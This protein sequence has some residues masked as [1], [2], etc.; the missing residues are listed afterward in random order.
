MTATAGLAAGLL[1]SAWLVALPARDRSL[2][3][4]RQ[5]DAVAAGGRWIRRVNVMGAVIGLIVLIPWSLSDLGLTSWL[6]VAGGFAIAAVGQR[7]LGRWQ[8]RR[9]RVERQHAVIEVCDA[10]AA[11]MRA[12]L[13]A[14]R[15]I[16]RAFDTWPEW[17]PVVSSARLGGDV[18]EILRGCAERPGSEG[19]RAVAAAW[20][21]AGRSGAGL[22]DVLDRVAA[23]L[24][25]DDEARAEVTAALG[26]PRATAKLLAALPVFGL[27]LGVSMGAH[28]VAF[29]LVS[30]VGLV[31]LAAGVIL[32]LLGV[33]WVEHLADAA[34]V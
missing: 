32:A 19:L 13:P 20:E 18:A 15:A 2:R 16:E 4:L 24:R 1:G 11:E 14:V 29:L 25:S 34:E 9:L 7:V 21:V 8:A 23:G 6:V 30:K 26:P 12:G 31:C 17:S 33:L 3:R 10:L 28:P 22:A 27:G 5:N